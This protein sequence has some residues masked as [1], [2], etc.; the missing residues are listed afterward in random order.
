MSLVYQKI[1]VTSYLIL[2]SEDF[3]IISSI[4]IVYIQTIVNIFNKD[5]D[6]G[7]LLGIC[8]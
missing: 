2:C 3:Y 6:Y 1:Q 4:S 5:M 7:G 8:M